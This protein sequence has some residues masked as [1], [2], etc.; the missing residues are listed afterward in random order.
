[1]E[2]KNYN[3]DG[4]EVFFNKQVCHIDVANILDEIA[5]NYLM[6]SLECQIESKFNT[7]TDVNSC[8][9]GINGTV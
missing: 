2:V 6:K 4:L 9:G 7:S 1:M 8:V 3:F 5:L